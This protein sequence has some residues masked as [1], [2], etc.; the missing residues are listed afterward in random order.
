M[1][2]H[3]TSTTINEYIFNLANRESCLRLDVCQPQVPRRDMILPRN[4]QLSLEMALDFKENPKYPNV[5]LVWWI[6]KDLLQG[7]VT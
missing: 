2:Y 7:N 5:H 3:I 6:S 1:L 4:V